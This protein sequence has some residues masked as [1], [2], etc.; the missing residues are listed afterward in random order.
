MKKICESEE[1]E[2]YRIHII[3]TNRRTISLSL[4]ENLDVL[5][6][7]PYFASDYDVMRLVREKSNWIK[8]HRSALLCRQEQ[9]APVERLTP[10]QL[11]K[12]AEE[13][14]EYIPKRV[15]FFARQLPVQ[16]GRIAIRNQRTR[17]GSCSQKGNLNFNCLLMLTPPEVIDYVV[18]HELCH[19]IEMN[20]S[21]RFWEQ[22]ECILPDYRR[23]RD[24]LKEN[25]HNLMRRM[26]G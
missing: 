12:L 13:A 17:W 23:Q 2:E 19:R 6:R 1:K 22:V 10:E 9:T 24:W 18:V 4:D 14:L 21:K 26:T 11:H 8:K 7:A 20:H 5:V 3:R 15:E 25:G 16:Y